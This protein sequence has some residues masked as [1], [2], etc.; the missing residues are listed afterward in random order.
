MVTE[1]SCKEKN[2]KHKVKKEE[3]KY[4]YEEQFLLIMT[5][6]SRFSYIWGSPYEEQFLLSNPLFNNILK[7]TPTL[8]YFKK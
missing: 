4:S 8:T 3:K 7:I 2:W 5:C 1:L 6:V